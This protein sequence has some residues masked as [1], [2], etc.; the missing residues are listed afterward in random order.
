[1]AIEHCQR[2]GRKE[3]FFACQALISAVQ[4]C[5]QHTV[6][7]FVLLQLA[8]LHTMEKGDAKLC[9]ELTQASTGDMRGL[10]LSRKTR[11]EFDGVF[12][13]A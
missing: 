2:S 6:C 7:C 12:R 13:I 5:L 8:G 1:M 11:L 10:E 9:D 3:I 4:P